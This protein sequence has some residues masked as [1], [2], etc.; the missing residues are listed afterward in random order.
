M[1]GRSTFKEFGLSNLLPIVTYS[2]PL[3]RRIVLPSNKDVVN[4]ILWNFYLYLNTALDPFSLLSYSMLFSGETIQIETR[5]ETLEK[6]K[7]LSS[8]FSVFSAIFSERLFWFLTLFQNCSSADGVEFYSTFGGFTYY[9]QSNSHEM[10][11][12]ITIL[13]VS[14]KF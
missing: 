10:F 14:E 3:R 8:L 9:F 7:A 11:L 12:K 4:F 13:E 6:T 1:A 2:V 5:S